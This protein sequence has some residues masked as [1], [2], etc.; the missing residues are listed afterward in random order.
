MPRRRRFTPAGVPVHVIQRGNN[1]T[2]TFHET[3]DY[4]RYRALLDGARRRTGCAIHAYVLMTNH[5]HLLVTP[6]RPTAVS[7]MMQIVGRRYVRYF[8]DRYVR[9]GTLWEGRFRAAPIDSERYFFTCAR[10]IELNPV[11]AGMVQHPR[12]YSWSSFRA[13][14]DGATES[15][16]EAHPLYEA[17]GHDPS[18]RAMKYAT[19]FGRSQDDDAVAAIR[20]ATN[21]GA[22]L[23]SL[24]GSESG[25]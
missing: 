11:R 6:A 19:L 8:N 7:E 16:I 22:P 18:D 3:Q 24:L 15:L 10:Y 23:M 5:V 1:R 17:L 12:D 25:I 20:R 9:T 21:S 14:A 2:P 4:T 13:N